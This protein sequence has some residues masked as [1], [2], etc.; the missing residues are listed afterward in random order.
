M[1]IFAVPNETIRRFS[2]EK[3]VEKFVGVSHKLLVSSIMQLNG[4][5]WI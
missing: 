4:V 1:T 2:G 5:D 3:G